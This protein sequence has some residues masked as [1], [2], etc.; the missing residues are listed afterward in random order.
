MLTDIDAIY[1]NGLLRPLAPLS[2]SENE[3]VK[4][5]V[6]RAGDEDWIDTEYMDACAG[7]ADF[8]ITLEQIRAITVKI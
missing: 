2:L 6:A 8:S 4:L 5:T 1:E 7:E 3:R